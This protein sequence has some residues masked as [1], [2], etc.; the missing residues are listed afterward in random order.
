M[1]VQPSGASVGSSSPDWGWARLGH[2]SRLGQSECVQGQL[3]LGVW[4]VGPPVFG[5]TAWGEGILRT[6]NLTKASWSHEGLNICEVGEGSVL[7]Q[8]LA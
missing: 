4:Q 7:F 5:F 6:V 8:L 1:W 3:S 2:V